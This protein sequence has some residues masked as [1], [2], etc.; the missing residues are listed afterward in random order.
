MAE[1]HKIY[2]HGRDNT[3]QQGIGRQGTVKRKGTV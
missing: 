3:V 2:R 1:K